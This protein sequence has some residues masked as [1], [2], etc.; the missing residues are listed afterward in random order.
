MHAYDHGLTPALGKN[1]RPYQKKK[2]L[3][4]KWGLE[5]GS[6]RRAPALQVI[7]PEFKSQY[8]KEKK[9]KFQ[10]VVFTKNFSFLEL[11]FSFSPPRYVVSVHRMLLFK[12]SKAWNQFS[13]F[14]WKL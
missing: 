3:K 13:S 7:G 14:Y 9:K 8:H 5:Y 12:T 2:K 6:S 4:Q 1:M 10:A 11:L